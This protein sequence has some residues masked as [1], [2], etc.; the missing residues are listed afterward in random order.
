MSLQNLQNELA[1]QSNIDL[2]I[3]RELGSD[4][5]SVLWYDIKKANM[6]NNGSKCHDLESF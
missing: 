3:N 6:C 4:T 5:I 2:F 1:F